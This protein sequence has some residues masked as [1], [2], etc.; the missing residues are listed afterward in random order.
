MNNGTLMLVG[1]MLVLGAFGAAYAAIKSAW[2]R[3]GRGAVL[4][5]LAI[6]LLG[7]AFG[8]MHLIRQPGF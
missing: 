8:I 1:I 6:V 2:T 3:P 4:L 7:A 5:C